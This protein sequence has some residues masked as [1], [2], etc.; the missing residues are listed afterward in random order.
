MSR[1][2]LRRQAARAATARAAALA[3]DSLGI[4]VEQRELGAY[5]RMF[6]LIEGGGGKEDT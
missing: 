2:R 5:D 1:S 6:T 4:E 3:P